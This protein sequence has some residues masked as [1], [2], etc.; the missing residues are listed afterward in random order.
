[1][2]G[3]TPRSRHSGFCYF[4]CGHN[5]PVIAIVVTGGRDYTNRYRV[6]TTLDQLHRKFG[7]TQL[8]HGACGWDADRAE[9][10]RIA[11]LRGA[12]GLADARCLSHQASRGH[13]S[14][15]RVPA[16]WSSL[17][18]RAGPERNGRMLDRRP[19][20]VVAFPGGSGTRNCVYQALE[21]GIEVLRA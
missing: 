11:L 7:I 10:H 2:G 4:V 17:G 6:F 13:L 14:V 9:T 21:R 18:G 1:M 15:V 3:T 16:H 5:C 8:I 20:L 19:D 12:D